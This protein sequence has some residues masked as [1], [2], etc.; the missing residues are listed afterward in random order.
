MRFRRIFLDRFGHFANATIDLGPRPEHGPDFA[1]LYGPNEAG[2]STLMAAILRLLFG[3]PKSRDPYGFL[4]GTELRVGAEIE[5]LP[6]HGRLSVWRI[7]R[8][9]ALIDADGRPVGD[10]LFEAALGGL[11]EADYRKIFSL[12]RD[13]VIEGSR[14]LSEGRGAAARAFFAAHTGLST[15]TQTLDAAEIEAADLYK[16]G[17]SKNAA[18][19]LLRE[20]D[21]LRKAAKEA[22]LTASAYAALK[23]EAASAA[24]LKTE[25]EVAL[26]EANAQALA[27]TRL[28]RLRDDGAALAAKRREAARFAGLPDWPADPHPKS[29]VE[30]NGERER[31]VAQRDALRARIAEIEARVEATPEDASILALAER[32]EAL[33]TAPE[34]GDASLHGG[35]AGAAAHLLRRR[36]EAEEIAGRMTRRLDA[37]R[38]EPGAP[39][40][41]ALVLPREA[42]AALEAAETALRG[43]EAAVETAREKRGEAE[44]D[45]D[46]VARER[47]QDLAAP[48]LSAEVAGAL[49]SLDPA[50]A[51]EAAE[52]A[53]AATAR[54]AEALSDALDAIQTPGR[55]FD[56][57]PETALTPGAVRAEDAE[58]A[59]RAQ[60]AE[61]ARARV[62]ALDAEIAEKAAEID[63]RERESGFRLT[64]PEA[65]RAARDEAW[66]RHR[67]ALD[68]ASA[69]AF[70]TEMRRHDMA[71][72]RRVAH[73]HALGAAAEAA[74]ALDA[75]R[76]ERAREAGKAEAADRDAAALDARRGAALDALGLP[77]ALTGEELAAWLEAARRAREAA[78]RLA[79][80]RALAAAPLARAETVAARVR[81]LLPQFAEA[82]D[83]RALRSA[84]ALLEAHGRE[85]RARETAQA[86]LARAESRIAD[87]AATLARAEEAL[88]AAEA[89]WRETVIRVLP[90][91]HGL[92]DV[93]G[94]VPALAEISTDGIGW[95]DLRRRVDAMRRDAAAYLRA[96]AA[97]EAAL[98]DG[99]G[100]APDDDPAALDDAALVRRVQAALAFER[101]LLDRLRAAREAGERRAA[102]LRALEEHR[103]AAAAL[104]AALAEA[105][106]AIA[107][108]RAPFPPERDTATPQALAAAVRDAAQATAARHAAREL[109]DSLRGRL[110]EDEG[111]DAAA[112]IASLGDRDLDAEKATAEARAAEATTAFR[113]A[114]ARASVAD[115]KLASVDGADAAA[116]ANAARAAREEQLVETLLSAARKRLG[117][118]LARAAVDAYREENRSAAMRAAAR[119]FEGLTRGRYTALTSRSEGGF[120]KLVARRATD[121]AERVA[122]QLSAGAR[123]QLFYALRLAAYR[124][125]VARGIACPFI[126]D[127]VF[128]SFDDHRTEAA[129]AEMREIGLVGQALYLTHHS[130]VARRAVA[131]CGGGDVVRLMPGA[132]REDVGE[133]EGALARL[134]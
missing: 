27:V 98:G 121:G 38:G 39:L 126:A 63:R 99:A 90:A 21:G 43:A 93:R 30:L 109:E 54:R 8:N 45:R 108:Y 80:E 125:Y 95:R 49:A 96:L 6:G 2:K 127:D 130:E 113:D 22:D 62:A 77:I 59:R 53:R 28:I 9:S 120:E 104:D 46:A 92:R 25:R 65:I 87:H 107:L 118:H 75:R 52:A 7:R 85:T 66:A 124:D 60:D 3:F 16:P 15:L 84:A 11:R 71:M 100:S 131:V 82:A 4:H 106:A 56:A 18:R 58:R 115:E 57:A 105:D 26:N 50:E 86:Q 1:V 70:E 89:R 17:G 42:M 55:S 64:D 44:A 12:D 83:E 103:A 34:D 72:D 40:S 101:D 119:A 36:S 32:V 114:F 20:I 78:R 61:T 37:R 133:A 48:A 33:A 35:A 91:D 13:G 110:T 81:T 24:R 128:E 97:I 117:L 123:M 10:D 29:L 73:A 102:D 23:R 111:A 41:E 76:R 68:A 69:E 5:D 112:F 129:C 31:L 74:A 19:G 132:A 94:S 79:G 134:A 122:D 51:A 88:R 14:E 67:A 47:A 116:R